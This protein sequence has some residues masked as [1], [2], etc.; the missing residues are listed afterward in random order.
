MSSAEENV[1]CRSFGEGDD[2][3]KTDGSREP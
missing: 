2:H 1:R 3:E